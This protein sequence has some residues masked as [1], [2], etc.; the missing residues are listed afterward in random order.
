ML[1]A[2]GEG[3][4][5]DE[6][7]VAQGVGEPG[8]AAGAGGD[9]EFLDEEGV[10]LGAGEDLVDGGVVGFGG[11][12]SGELAGDLGAV[13]AGQFEALDGAQPVEFGEE[14][15]ERVAPVDVVGAVAGED[16]EAA[17]AQGAEEVGDEAAGGG[18]G[19]VQ[20]LDDEDDGAGGGEVFEETGGQVEEAGGAFL[21][22]AGEGGFAEVG[23]EPGEFALL[24][25]G[26]GGELLGE[27]AAQGAQHGGERGEGQSFGAALHAG[28]EGD[29]GPVSGGFGGE[30]LQEPGLADAGLAADQQGP[31]F[32]CP[33]LRQRPAE[34]V[35]FC[36]A[37][38][39][40]RAD[41]LVFHA[42]EH[43]IRLPHRG[44]P[45]GRRC[46]PRGPVRGVH[47]AE[48]RGGRTS[49]SFLSWPVLRAG[50]PVA[51]GCSARRA[52]R[53]CAASSMSSAERSR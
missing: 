33:Y 19:P 14:G 45:A 44:G 41:R 16:E 48:A 11:E 7:E 23:Q 38:D 22:G 5:A 2:F 40:D 51:G 9:G 1:A 53:S 39:E 30:L 52:S 17:G 31:G 50:R 15:P 25:G 13:E 37:S 32:S 36:G 8:V 29:E 18:V 28:A 12:D 49:R 35:E 34:G 10:A 26:A 42:G 24:P 46:G 3:F 27:Q 20:V 6:E 4:D 43:R 21:A 47:A